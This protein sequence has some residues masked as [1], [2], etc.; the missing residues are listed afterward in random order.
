MAADD[1]TVI[2]YDINQIKGQGYEFDDVVTKRGLD[3]MTR[4]V[5][6]MKDVIS[7]L[8]SYFDGEIREVSLI[9]KDKQG[10]QKLLVEQPLM[11]VVDY[12]L[13]IKEIQYL[14]SIDPYLIAI[15]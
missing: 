13:T 9:V 4:R 12:L 14:K 6:V 11:L 2:L 3:V 1:T 8:H 15:M 10:N 7:S 5:D